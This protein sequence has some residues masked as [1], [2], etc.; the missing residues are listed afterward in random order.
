M[1]EAFVEPAAV[2]A[3]L[4]DMPMFL[5][6]EVYVPVPLEM[7]YMSAWESVPAYWREVL[8]AGGS[9]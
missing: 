4:A 6:P 8:T 3:V 7:T 2:G 9:V 5:T 1:P